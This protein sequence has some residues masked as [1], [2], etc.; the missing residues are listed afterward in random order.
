MISIKDA[1]VALDV[2]AKGLKPLTAEAA[3]YVKSNTTEKNELYEKFISIVVNKGPLK[4][5]LTFLQK[6]KVLY[7]SDALTKVDAKT[8]MLVEAKFLKKSRSLLKK[9]TIFLLHLELLT[10]YRTYST[11]QDR[12]GQSL[13]NGVA[14]LETLMQR[15]TKSLRSS[16][17]SSPTSVTQAAI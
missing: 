3:S 9:A 1:G 17:A 13:Q 6:Y 15:I 5:L 11:E 10:T 4:P 16:P 14:T 7:T 8:R 12:L 2:I